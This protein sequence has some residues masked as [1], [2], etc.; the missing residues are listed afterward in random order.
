MPAPGATEYQNTPPVRG[1]LAGAPDTSPQEPEGVDHPATTHEIVRDIP[2]H[3]I[4]GNVPDFI[5][6]KTIKMMDRSRGIR[7]THDQYTFIGEDHNA[8]LLKHASGEYIA[9][10]TGSKKS[11]YL[12]TYEHFFPNL[13]VYYYEG[14]LLKPNIEREIEGTYIINVKGIG[15]S[16]WY[17]D[18]GRSRYT[19]LHD[20]YIPEAEI[21]V[22]NGKIYDLIVVDRAV[23]DSSDR[24][25]SERIREREPGSTRLI[26]RDESGK[27]WPVRNQAFPLLNLATDNKGR[28][29][30]K[31]SHRVG[32]TDFFFMFIPNY[33]WLGEF[34]YDGSGN[35]SNIHFF[36][37]EGETLR[38]A[39]EAE[40]ESLVELDTI[41]LHSAYERFS[42][43][44]P[45]AEFNY[46]R[47]TPVGRLTKTR[48]KVP[49][50][51]RMVEVYHQR[52]NIHTKPYNTTIEL[53]IEA[54]DKKEYEERF[55]HIKDLLER[56]PI[57]LFRQIRRL[58]LYKDSAT[59]YK[60]L[61]YDMD[62]VFYGRERKISLFTFR[63]NSNSA[64]KLLHHELWHSLHGQRK[65]SLW[66]KIVLAIKV[67]DLRHEEDFI[68]RTLESD[69]H[70]R[71]WEEYIA[72]A[73]SLLFVS[74]PEEAPKDMVIK[75]ALA[76]PMIASALMMIIDDHELEPTEETIAI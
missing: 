6:D 42:P 69:Y 44:S 71:S 66:Q 34:E 57:P 17:Y 23:L 51:P 8:I 2:E 50:G 52:L 7:S 32:D 70:L 55:K 75:T 31:G 25:V 61:S 11:D 30:I 59:S 49:D 4:E 1:V 9:M 37:R 43:A 72:E 58:E 60:L 15:R 16:V 74:G 14:K 29:Y 45:Y 41:K 64:L 39:T 67:G 76:M 62:G 40:L 68:A 47:V 18:P 5:I 65:A 28:A 19:S 22:D 63:D 26:V 38:P 73:G 24:T 27:Y 54:S 33:S 53:V 20:A 36:K 56:T 21:G 48:T 35:P 12:Y 13:G 10:E 3:P 46:P